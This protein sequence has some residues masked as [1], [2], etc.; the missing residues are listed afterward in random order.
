MNKHTY[1]VLEYLQFLEL[2]SG[3]TQ[4][5]LGADIVK[6]IR[7]HNQLKDIQTKRGLYADLL[8]MAETAL[9]HPPLRIDDISQILREVAPEGAVVS[10]I[11]LVAVK[12]V[13]EVCGDLADFLAKPECQDFSNLQQL[14][15]PLNPCGQLKYDIARSIDTDGSV[16]DSASPKLRELRRDCVATESR[17]QRRLEAIIKSPAMGDGTQDKFVTMRNGRFVIPVKKDA[18]TGLTGIVHD[19]SQSG[20]TMFVEPNETLGWGND[21]ARLRIEERDE[22]RRILAVLSGQVRLASGSIRTNQQIIA[23]IDAAAAVSRWAIAYNAYLPTFGGYLSLK[24]ARHP[25]LL[26]QFR[27]IAGGREVVP[28]DLELPKNSKTLAITGSNTGGKTI[29]LKTTGLLALIA[30]SGLP[31]PASPDSQFDIY[32]G[33][34]ADIGDEQSIEANLSTYSGHITNIASILQ[35]TLNGKSLVLLDELGSGTDPLEGGA[36]GCAIL[37]ELLK[38][39][40]IT[41]ATTHLGMVKNFVQQHPRMTNAAVRF[42]I[43]SL[44]P[45][46]IL[47]I[48]RPGAS[49][50]LLTAKRIGLPKTVLD[51]AEKYLSGEHLKMEE[52]LA[53]IEADQKAIEDQTRQIT[54][55]NKELTE[56]RDQLQV[57]LDTLK[58]E[59]KKLS[60]EAFQKAQAIVD[61]TRREME[62]LVRELRERAK[63]Q[64]LSK[65]DEGAE[66]VAKIREKLA[67]RERRIQ[68][69]IRTSQERPK[70]PIEPKSLKVGAKVWIEKLHAHGKI[71]SLS[72]NKKQ[73]VVNIDGIPFTMKASELQHPTEKD[74]KPASPQKSVV[75]VIAP[76]VTGDTSHELNL[77]G[78]RVD[79]ALIELESFI[80]RSIL[81]RIEEVRVVH[82]FGTGR[83][84]AGIHDWLKKQP[85]IKSFRLGKEPNEP[86]GAGCTVVKL[87][88]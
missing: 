44:K 41:I 60:N 38:R 19:L 1:K 62:N 24:Q 31:V 68:E 78:Q 51:T 23:Q 49:Y 9:S 56:K 63:S 35:D 39:N 53:K 52:M 17:I 30:Q 64:A 71:Q 14:A 11:D 76:V 77:I 59:R 20:Q 85:A 27:R 18:R 10:G 28:L 54:Q 37:N 33:I 65:E 42:D 32:D 25:L 22:V 26:A 43:E 13:L 3:Y 67:D 16:L 34:Y 4:S 7:P 12:S 5:Q 72:D 79:D 61:N 57:E 15:K 45:L 87:K 29:A 46:F 74:A 6:A 47:D 36:I 50:A 80:N 66:G 81:A 70:A 84:R 82:G 21:L 86:G 83:L 48:G 40:A 55:A 58:R 75:K 8:A 69:G 2:V 73:I 88:L